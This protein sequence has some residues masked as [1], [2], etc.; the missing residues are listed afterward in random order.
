MIA[1]WEKG[2]LLKVAKKEIVLIGDLRIYVDAFDFSIIKDIP[3][4]RI[5]E[6]HRETRHFASRFGGGLVELPAD[7]A[8]VPEEIAPLEA[9]Y[10]EQLLQ[11][12]SDY[13]ATKLNSKADLEA[14][15]LLRKH[16]DRQR[17]HFYLAELLRNFTRDNIPEDGCFE[18]L[19]QIIY[20]GVIDTAE[21]THPDGFAR[22]KETIK[23]ARAIQI[24]SHPLK[25]CLEGYHRSGICHQLAN[26]DQLKWVP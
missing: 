3:P 18:R 1:Q 19:Q 9:H 8:V 4:S 25:E 5:I 21:G 15:P 20:D 6:Q 7:K 22:L 11:A 2:D 10:V 26:E 24:D 17:T 14:H 23:Q 12:Y 16:F 13:L